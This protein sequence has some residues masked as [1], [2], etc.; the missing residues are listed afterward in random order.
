MDRRERPPAAAGRHGDWPRRTAPLG[1]GHGAARSAAARRDRGEGPPAAARSRPDP[2]RIALDA[3]RRPLRLVVGAEGQDAAL[4]G[5]E[6]IPAQA[7]APG[8]LG[9]AAARGDGRPRPAP[10]RRQGGHSRPQVPERPARLP[11]QHLRGG[12]EDRWTVGGAPEPHRGG[13]AVQGGSET[14]ED[15][16]ALGVG[17]GARGGPAG[18]AGPGGDRPLRR[19]ARGGDLR[20][21][22]G[23]RGSRGRH[24]HGEP[25]LG[26]AAH[27]GRQGATGAHRRSAPA[28]PH[29]GAARGARPARVPEGRRHHALAQAA[30]QPDAP[31]RHRPRRPHRGLRAPLPG[32]ALRLEGAAALRGAPGGVPELR[33]AITLGEARPAA[34]PLPRHPP[35]R[36]HGGGAERG[37]GSRAEVPPPLGR[38]PHHPHLRPPG[39]RGRPGGAVPV[40]HHRPGDGPDCWRTARG[41][42]GGRKREAAQR[43]ELP[44]TRRKSPSRLHDSGSDP[45]RTRARRARSAASA[46][47]RCSSAA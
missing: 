25:V 16:H 8:H 27:E 13:R 18:M 7:P 4:D 26:C 43:T 36:R 2:Q 21:A 5:G 3:L 34:R 9:D 29:E 19:D 37:H 44:T 12:A 35:L 31:G 46:R 1:P 28:A 42:G 47:T 39:R 41:V 40:V 17:A 24:H 15:P 20:D 30:T 23:G 6:A 11:V 22:Q 14:E 10:P 38:A 33:Q 32:R 45:L